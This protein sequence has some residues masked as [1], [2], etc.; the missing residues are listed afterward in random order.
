MDFKDQRVLVVGGSSGIGRAT[1]ELLS[2]TGAEVVV[3]GRSADRLGEVAARSA[4]R[5]ERVD[6]MD[7]AALDELF[8]RLAPVDHL[9]V[10]VSGGEGAGPFAGLDLD[11]VRRAFAAKTFAQLEV[12]QAA[13]P[14]MRASGSITLVTAGSAQA[15]LP[16]TVGLAAVNGALEAAVRPLAAELAPIRVNAVSPGVVNTAWWESMPPAQRAAFFTEFASRTPLGRVAEPEEVARA[17][18]L[19]IGSTFV[20]GHTLV[21]DGGLH[22][23]R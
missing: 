7:R 22:L 20:T 4:I 8:A 10:C 21:A 15:A 1:A 2:Q 11:A 13:L 12:V 23:A 9:V 17:V 5:T 19:L 6:A 3:A 16:G 14:A 18:M